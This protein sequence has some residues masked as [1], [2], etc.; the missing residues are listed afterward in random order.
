M[1]MKSRILSILS[2]SALVLTPPVV[3]FVHDPIW[4]GVII[5][6]L[7]LITFSCEIARRRRKQ[8]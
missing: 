1:S 7:L 2:W 4:R 5:F 3:F 6:L 8:Q